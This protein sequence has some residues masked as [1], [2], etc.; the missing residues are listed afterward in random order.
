[1]RTDFTQCKSKTFSFPGPDFT[2]TYFITRRK[3]KKTPAIN[4]DA[5]RTRNP[6]VLI[7]MI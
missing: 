5:S 4:L 6:A 7:K 3:K 1:M 2:G